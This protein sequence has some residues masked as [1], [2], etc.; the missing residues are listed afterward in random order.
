MCVCERL[1]DWQKELT[2]FR[3][4][5]HNSR[6]PPLTLLRSVAETDPKGVAV[7]QAKAQ[8]QGRSCSADFLNI[9][10]WQAL[11]I[12]G[13]C[14]KF[15]STTVNRPGAER[16]LFEFTKTY[17]NKLLKCSLRKHIITWVPCKLLHIPETNNEQE[18]VACESFLDI[19]KYKE[20]RKCVNTIS[21]WIRSINIY[22]TTAV[23]LLSPMISILALQLR[24]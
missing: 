11:T 1:W 21:T 15:I 22:D 5:S 17:K 24:C 10:S 19:Y 8:Q 12:C 23:K 9:L 6:L 7:G 16:C 20:R 14:Q 13:G 3:R 4:L 2:V 18:N